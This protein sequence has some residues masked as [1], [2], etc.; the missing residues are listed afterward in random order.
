MADSQ[1]VYT[2]QAG[3]K[4]ILRKQPDQFV[5]RALPGELKDLGVHDAEQVS[6]RSSR[7]TTRIPDLEPMM[8]EAR[9]LAP[10]HH[11]YYQADT[12]EEFL[13]TDRVFVTF[14]RPLRPEEVDA[15]AARY[16]LQI[17]ERY[18]EREYL[19]QL[20][21]HTGMNPVKLVVKMTEE[22]PLVSV[23][24]HDLN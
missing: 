10:T 11:A 18:S 12:G 13:I 15:F 21:N 16:G 5:V 8:S 14:R 7:V 20:T 4:I 23:A 19:F 9:E 6:S 1:E 2:Y 17:K 24:E 3:Q 22:E